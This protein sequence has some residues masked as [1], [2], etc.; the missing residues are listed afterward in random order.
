[1]DPVVAIG[2]FFPRFI[3]NWNRT[4][5]VNI[6][7]QALVGRGDIF[8]HCPLR[9]GI[10]VKDM[11]RMEKEVS[12]YAKQV[13]QTLQQSGYALPSPG[14]PIMVWDYKRGPLLGVKL[15]VGI[16]LDETS[17][18]ILEDEGWSITPQGW[19]RLR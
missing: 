11:Q 5:R 3:Q 17:Q 13:Q 6:P 7:V 8:L 9:S 12:G 16:E 15:S 18:E 10:T 14:Q 1:M 2:Y 4:A 19:K